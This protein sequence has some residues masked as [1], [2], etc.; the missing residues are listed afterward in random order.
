MLTTSSPIAD[1]LFC[2]FKST[3]VNSKKPIGWPPVV[4]CASK[5]PVANNS[6]QSFLSISYDLVDHCTLLVHNRTTNI[7]G[8]SFTS[9]ASVRDEISSLGKKLLVLAEDHED[10]DDDDDDDELELKNV[11]SLINYL[12]LFFLLYR[13][14]TLN[15]EN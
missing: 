10:D 3:N 11:V 14:R 6:F 15:G 9:R 7:I 4:S 1:P 8:R 12:P 5:F 13:D 2:K